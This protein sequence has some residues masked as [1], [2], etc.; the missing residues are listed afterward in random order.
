[1]IATAATYAQIYRNAMGLH[2]LRQM[3]DALDGIEFAWPRFVVRY[4]PFDFERDA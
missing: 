3:A 4:R 2:P 1:M